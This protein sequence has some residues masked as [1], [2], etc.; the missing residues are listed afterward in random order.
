MHYSKVKEGV[1]LERPNRFIAR[2]MLDGKEEVCHVKNTG[3]C[4]ELLIPGKTKVYVTDHGPETTR[5]TRYSLIQVVK[6]DRLINMD[7]QA[8]NKVALE[9]ILEGGFFKQVTYVKPEYQYGKSRIDLYVEADGKRNLIEVK[10][11]TLEEDNIARFPDA[12]TLRGVKHI[13]ELCEAR[14]EGYEAFILFVIQMEGIQMFMPNDQT[15]PEFGQALLYARENGVNIVA[16][17][18][19]VGIGTLRIHDFVSVNLDN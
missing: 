19:E 3:R 11:V 9:W 6:N 14:K 1:F 13:Y 10:G 16:V 7:S 18:C 8:P 12:P 4:R 17:D 2:V 15:H 5:K